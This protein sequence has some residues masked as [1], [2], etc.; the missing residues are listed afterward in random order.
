VGRLAIQMAART[1]GAARVISSGSSP[2]SIELARSCGAHHV[3]DHKRDDALVEITEL[4]DGA[5]V[6]VVHDSTY[7]ET[8]FV[9]TARMV[10]NGGKWV[11]LGVGPGK[12]TRTA[13]TESPRWRHPGRAR[14][15]AHQRQHAQILST[16]P[17]R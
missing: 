1:L 14:R 6:D 9:D 8:G 12:T 5:G 17:R 10:R 16:N 3:F 7:S 15:P 2:S 13:Q 11:V 4:T